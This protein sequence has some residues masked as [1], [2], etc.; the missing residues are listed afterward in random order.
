MFN[1]FHNGMGTGGWVLMALFWLALLALVVWALVRLLPARADD[2]RD[3]PVAP[4]EILDR[5]LAAGEIDAQTYEQ[6][7]ATLDPR[8]LPGRG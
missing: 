7:R 8:S 4:R 5:R 1:G 6:L 3:A 2:R